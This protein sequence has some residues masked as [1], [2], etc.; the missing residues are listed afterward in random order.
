VLTN[1]VLISRGAFLFT[2]L[3]TMAKWRRRALSLRGGRLKSVDGTYRIMMGGVLYIS[4]RKTAM[5]RLSNSEE[6]G[7]ERKV[8]RMAEQPSIWQQLEAMWQC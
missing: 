7:L 2:L 1:L 8:T 4:L 3:L 5:L 6:K